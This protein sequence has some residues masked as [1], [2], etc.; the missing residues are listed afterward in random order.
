MC[1]Y[2]LSLDPQL[3]FECTG[4]VGLVQGTRYQVFRPR[5]VPSPGHTR[6]YNKGRGHLRHHRKPPP[7]TLGTGSFVTSTD[8]GRVWVL[9]GSSSI[10]N[11]P[12][13]SRRPKTHLLPVEVSVAPSRVGGSGGPW[14]SPPG[15]PGSRPGRS[16]DERR[17]DRRKVPGE[18]NQ[19]TL[20]E[21]P[22]CQGGR[23]PPTGRGPGRAPGDLI[24]LEPQHQV[25]VSPLRRRAG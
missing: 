18:R 21:G 14:S 23:D 11:V 5:P 13:P 10:L 20:K 9:P 15:E 25:G 7:G 17:G 19:R 2:Q 24:E 8:P 6:S 16:R 22:G 1:R 4:Q 3:K 12:L